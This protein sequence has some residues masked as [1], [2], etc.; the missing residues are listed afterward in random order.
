MDA[1][2][3]KGYGDAEMIQD[4]LLG[5]ARSKSKADNNLTSEAAFDALIKT[6]SS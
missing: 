2:I 5:L 4:L 3:N 6:F 1:I